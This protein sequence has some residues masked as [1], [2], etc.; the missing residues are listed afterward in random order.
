MNIPG[1]RL[2]TDSV[3]REIYLSRIVGG[4]IFDR[5]TAEE[6]C[7]KI[8]VSL[9]WD[10]F[11]CAVIYFDENAEGIN[12]ASEKV[13]STL[14]EIYSALP[15]IFE[16]EYRAYIAFNERHLN[17]IVNLPAECV[18]QPVPG[19]V[20]AAAR[21]VGA[22][23]EKVACH[24]RE[25]TG[26]QLLCAIGD[27]VVGF[28]S[29]HNSNREAK[30][31]LDYA[32]LLGIEKPVVYY[33]DYATPPLKSTTIIQDCLEKRV[34][35]C[36]RAGDYQGVA[37]TLHNVA[38][39]FFTKSAPS[40]HV[41]ECRFGALKSLLINVLNDIQQDIGEEFF[42]RDHSI[43]FIINTHSL[44]D[45]FSMTDS[46][47]EKIIAATE[48][49]RAQSVPAWLMPVREY[50]DRDYTNGNLN[51]STVAGMFGLNPTQLSNSFREHFGIGLLEYIHMLRLSD[52]KQLLGQGMNL[53]SIA[54]RIGYSS[55]R[56]MRRAFAKYEGVTPGRL[57]RLS[58]DPSFNI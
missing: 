36:A 34:F 23:L 22:R 58:R 11:I 40:I 37:A 38:D 54:E 20:T 10:G 35:N 27:A 24:M 42:I 18:E 12:G 41:A 7:G 16:P 21:A 31:T 51:I 1:K 26:V 49:E 6:L 17:C 55:T 2:S 25:K 19:Q 39:E 15:A 57:N 50:I 8:D 9:P 28:E 48:E 32:R 43:S 14:D 30:A 46:L 56:T 29:I 47:F 5:E 44:S 53:D 33:Q 52:A 4:L 13:N 45:F 3:L